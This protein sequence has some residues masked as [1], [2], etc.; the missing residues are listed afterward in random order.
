MKSGWT[1]LRHYRGSRIAVST[2]GASPS[3]CA[4]STVRPALGASLGRGLLPLNEKPA[5]GPIQDREPKSR[6]VWEER[7]VAI[8][9]TVCS[10]RC[11]VRDLLGG[12]LGGTGLQ[13][14]AKSSL[15]I[16]NDW[17]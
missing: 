14:R 8:S 12:N 1:N 7:L 11:I 3:I 4:R 13:S 2:F 9:I 16:F 15:Q 17:T 6:E 5:D 10:L